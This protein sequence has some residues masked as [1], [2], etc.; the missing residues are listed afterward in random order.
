MKDLDISKYKLT[1]ERKGTDTLP[2]G[3]ERK[4]WVSIYSDYPKN[5]NY[6]LSFWQIAGVRPNQDLNV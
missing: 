2:E 3:Y 5:L 6:D 1:I 4:G